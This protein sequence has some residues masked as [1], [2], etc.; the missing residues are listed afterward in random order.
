MGKAFDIQPRA[1]ALVDT[2]FRRIVTKIPAPQSL[3][4]LEILHRFEPVSM[5]GQPPI[6]WDKAEGCQVYDRY[7]NMWLDWSSGV[8]V[9][10]AGHGAKEVKDAILNQVEKGLL[11][12]Y[13]FPSAE[14]AALVQY[15]A[16]LCPEPLKK[17]F[18]LTTGSEATE[19]AVKLSRTHGQRVGGKRKNGIV[20][21]QAA[22]HGRTLG[23][24]MIGGI[25]ALKEWI[26]NLDPDTHQVPFPDGFRTEDTRFEVFMGTL[27]EQ[28]VRPGQVAGVILE[29]YQGGSASFAPK[30]YIQKLAR[31][32]REHN[33][34]LTFDEIQAGFG[35]TG[36]LFGFEHYGV[37]PD[38][39]CCGKGISSSLPLSAVIG[40]PDVMDLY[41]PAEMTSTHTGNP[42]CTAS[43]LASLRRIV[44]GG[45]VE[46]A[47]AMGDVL[48]DGL[49]QIQK[50]HP[51][52]IGAVQG[53][54]L[55]AGLHMVKAGG[56][57]PDGDLAFLVVQKAFQ[58]GLLMF[59][60]VGVGGATVK[61]APPLPIAKD[62]VLDG[63]SALG[64]AI[65]EATR[66][67]GLN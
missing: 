30:E 1:V 39:I 18:L 7:G 53:R 40:R 4:V 23:A 65:D 42:V 47:K 27:E 22:F 62:A 61:I 63:L 38:L 19:C 56:K 51:R 49:E 36:T 46:N 59:A 44:E 13:C 52:I 26:V 6:V 58:K 11:H 45:L 57:E 20:S 64:E 29:T 10:N 48:L 67:L 31:W 24:Q 35:R 50:R 55:V 60:P 25:P 8:L 5:T 16:G 3:E 41:G 2:G 15:L 37:V 9:T 66:E 54:G 33:V 28:R 14:R 21:F 34:L 32:C 12:N 43:A 17:V